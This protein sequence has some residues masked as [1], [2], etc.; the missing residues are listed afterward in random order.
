MKPGLTADAFH[1]TC[2]YAFFFDATGRD[3]YADADQGTLGPAP[4]APL[5]PPPRTAL[6]LRTLRLWR[7]LSSHDVARLRRSLRDMRDNRDTADRLG[8]NT[9]PPPP[10][11]CCQA[12]CAGEDAVENI[13]GSGDAWSPSCPPP[14]VIS[15]SGGDE[16]EAPPQP[17]NEGEDDAEDKLIAGGGGEE[18]DGDTCMDGDTHISSDA[19]VVAGEVD[20]RAP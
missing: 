12:D 15:G 4:A 5:L 9:T 1:G 18:E 17:R 2:G 7:S 16:G 8:D 6:D 20:G 19:D 3:R 11:S 14:R 10:A 13:S